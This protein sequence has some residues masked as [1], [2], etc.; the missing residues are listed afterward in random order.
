[1]IVSEV[2]ACLCYSKLR[3]NLSL[4]QRIDPQRLIPSSNDPSSPPFLP[5]KA[6]LPFFPKK[7]TCFD[8]VSKKRREKKLANF[9][10][11]GILIGFRRGL[12]TFWGEMK[13][14]ILILGLWELILIYAFLT[15]LLG[16]FPHE[17]NEKESRS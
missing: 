8:I 12:Q 4:F 10:R 16:K 7:A 13:Q 14:N 11:R 3:F 17:D 1:M 6:I 2:N 15:E 9:F 5:G